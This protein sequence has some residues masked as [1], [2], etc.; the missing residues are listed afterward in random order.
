[1]KQLAALTAFLVLSTAAQATPET[2]VID[3]SQTVA[4]FS[5]SYMGIPSN[6]NKFEKT[7]GKVVFDAATRTGSADVT[8]DASSIETGN[9]LFNHQMQSK[10]FFDSANHP[11]ITFK[12]TR[13]VL[14]GEQMSMSGDLTVKGV[15]RPVT[16]MVSRFECAQ[17]PVNKID[18]CAAHATLTIKRSEFNMSKF[19]M[20]AS[21]EVT[22]NLSIAA[23]KAQPVIQLASRDSSR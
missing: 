18:A 6:G 1:M 15:T 10:G 11:V 8:I 14:D 3:D 7:T 12:S 4:N 16:L 13:M 20:L 9:A 19:K 2:Y 5:F 21:N 22:L 17:H 23:V